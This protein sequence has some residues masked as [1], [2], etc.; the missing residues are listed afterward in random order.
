MM[1]PTL[2]LTLYITACYTRQLCALK[3]DM[4]QTLTVLQ[5]LTLD[6][7]LALIHAYDCHLE[8]VRRGKQRTSD[9]FLFFAVK[10]ITFTYFIYFCDL[11]NMFL[12][13]LHFRC[14][15]TLQEKLCHF[16]NNTFFQSLITTVGLA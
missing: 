11:L 15:S 10:R 3:T 1:K 2:T 14:S 12:I 16:L 7:E 4:D 8:K 13:F 5:T 9:S 6:T